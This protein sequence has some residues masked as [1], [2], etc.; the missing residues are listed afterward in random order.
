M[1]RKYQRNV[2]DSIQVLHRSKLSDIYLGPLLFAAAL[3]AAV[4]CSPQFSVRRHFQFAAIFDSP[5][6]FVR[7]RFQF[8]AVLNSP[9]FSVR[10]QHDPPLP[11]FVVVFYSPS[12][13]VRRRL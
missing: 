2:T 8:A 3:F 13:S 4:F 9:S 5:P 7:R 11:R 12:F 10:R 6:F 1:V